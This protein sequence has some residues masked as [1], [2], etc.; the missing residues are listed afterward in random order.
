METGTYH[1]SEPQNYQCDIKQCF[2]TSEAGAASFR[3]VW[4][5]NLHC[6]VPLDGKTNE[7]RT[8]YLSE[9]AAL[10]FRYGNQ[11]LLEVLR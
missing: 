2:V 6:D 3:N 11:K 4:S 10:P 9:S 7:E 5:K 1:S 8:E